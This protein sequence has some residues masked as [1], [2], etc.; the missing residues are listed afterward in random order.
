MQDES[1]KEQVLQIY[2]RGDGM[3][4]PD[5][6]LKGKV[7]LITGRS[8]GIGKATALGFARAVTLS[9]KVT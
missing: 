2:M 9:Q 4:K 3:T 7:T 1:I 6:S 8:H 5:F